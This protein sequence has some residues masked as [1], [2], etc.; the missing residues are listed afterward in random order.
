MTSLTQT[1]EGA[2]KTPESNLEKY[3]RHT[4]NATCFLAWMAGI[5]VAISIIAGI[6]TAVHI[7]DVNN[8]YN[9]VTNCQSLGGTNPN[10]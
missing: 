7:S 6:A 10:C 5:L 8:Q 4:R 9:S 2:A 1:L 3:S